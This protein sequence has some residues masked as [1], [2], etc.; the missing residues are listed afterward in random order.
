M[1]IPSILRHWFTLAATAA[2]AWLVATLTLSPDDQALLTTAFADL[3]GPLVIIGTLVVTALW[4]VALVWMARIFRTGSG[5]NGE[6]SRGGPGGLPLWI[7][8]A[9]G[10]FICG[11]LPSCGLPVRATVILPEGAVSYSAKGGLEL[12]VDRRSYK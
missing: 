4:R 1:D 6:K 10:A 12:H 8:G 2:T 3:V 7:I 11:S 5:E 9:A